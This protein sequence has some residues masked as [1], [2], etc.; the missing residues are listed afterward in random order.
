VPTRFSN[1]SGS[2]STSL[3][4]YVTKALYDF[5]GHSGGRVY[6]STGLRLEGVSQGFNDNAFERG[7]VAHGAPYVTA[8]KAGRSEGGPAMEPARAKKRLP[9]LA[10]GAM[11][12]LFAP[13]DKWMQN[14]PWIAADAS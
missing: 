4:L 2:N 12:F 11:V 1:A 3:G 14:D 13:N 10:Q 7:V 9:K 6:T 5:R 8:T